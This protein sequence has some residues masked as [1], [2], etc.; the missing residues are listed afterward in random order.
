M[1]GAGCAARQQHDENEEDADCYC[2]RRGVRFRNG[3]GYEMVWLLAVG[4]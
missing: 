2:D 1:G 4:I 3:I